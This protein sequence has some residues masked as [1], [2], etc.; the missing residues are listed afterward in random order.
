MNFLTRF[1]QGVFF[2]IF[3]KIYN[4]KAF[5]FS[6]IFLNVPGHACFEPF[7]FCKIQKIWCMM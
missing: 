7:V 1:P 5:V 3:A 2:N 6:V 4:G